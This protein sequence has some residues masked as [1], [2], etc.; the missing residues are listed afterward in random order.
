VPL[1]LFRKLEPRIG[2]LPKHLTMIFL[3]HLTQESHAFRCVLPVL[4]GFLHDV[5]YSLGPTSSA[6]V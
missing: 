6:S 1:A 2:H 5:A 4:L 3:I